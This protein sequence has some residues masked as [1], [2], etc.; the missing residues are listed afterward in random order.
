MARRTGALLPVAVA[1]SEQVVRE[2]RCAH[3]G[4]E[5]DLRWGLRENSEIE[6]RGTVSRR[7]AALGACDPAP[8]LSQTPTGTA[9]RP[10][11]G[12]KYAIVESMIVLKQRRNRTPFVGF[13]RRSRWTSWEVPFGGQQHL[14][15]CYATARIVIGF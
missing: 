12:R 6:G 4:W 14:M 11:F 3:D 10:D 13:V 8:W 7:E 9:M 1:R 5:V 15:M 2:A